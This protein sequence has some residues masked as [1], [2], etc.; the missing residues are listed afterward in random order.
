MTD[1]DL[2]QRARR[3]WDAITSEPKDSY[4]RYDEERCT[5]WF[6]EYAEPLMD[7][8]G[9]AEEDVRIARTQRDE[10]RKELLERVTRE[11]ELANKERDGMWCE[12]DQARQERDAAL[13]REAALREALVAVDE[14]PEMWCGENCK[15]TWDVHNPVR[16]ACSCGAAGVREKMRAALASS[17][18]TASAFVERIRDEARA[19]EREAWAM[20]L[21]ELARHAN[22]CAVTFTDEDAK[23]KARLERDN[24]MAAAE[25]LRQRHDAQ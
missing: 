12:R 13:S 10:A 24:Y 6:D 18:S 5:K 20:R 16:P 21:D 15:S 3:G 8:L 4:G 1:T 23:Q 14:A 25:I 22:R 9:A 11:I 2:L 19:E 17:A 7:A